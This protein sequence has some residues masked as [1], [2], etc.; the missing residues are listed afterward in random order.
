MGNERTERGS[1]EA[2]TNDQLGKASWYKRT[3]L[4]HVL[5]ICIHNKDHHT[6]Q[7]K[8]LE[9]LV[10]L[11]NGHKLVEHGRHQV[12]YCTKQ[13]SNKDVHVLLLIS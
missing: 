10:K 3:L 6:Y 11:F 12:R 13:Q 7:S 8:D 2:Q 5:Y 9:M 4:L 1:R